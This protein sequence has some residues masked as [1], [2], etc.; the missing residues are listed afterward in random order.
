M[1]GYILNKEMKYKKGQPREGHLWT[2]IGTN[3]PMGKKVFGIK[4]P[5]PFEEYL[6]TLD[7]LERVALIRNSIIQGVSEYALDQGDIE[8]LQLIQQGIE[9]ING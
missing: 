2:P 1:K 4:L 3:V 8:G 5:K 7:R 6:L 9:Q